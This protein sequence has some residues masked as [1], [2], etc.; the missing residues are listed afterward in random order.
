MFSLNDI[1][2]GNN[3][4]KV[5]AGLPP[6]ASWFRTHPE[7]VFRNAKVLFVPKANEWWLLGQQAGAA[8]G[9]VADLYLG[10]DT[11]ATPWILVVTHASGPRVRDAI[12]KARTVW[13]KRVAG[14]GPELV[15]EDSP[16]MEHRAPVWPEEDFTQLL[17]EAFA[18][19]FINDPDHP[20]LR[21]G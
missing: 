21:A 12:E 2:V 8:G 17:N 11:S 4:A 7:L 5:M 16:V 1:A 18:G 19:R 20:L 6:K 9:Y 13:T 15:F 14:T 3:R 10:T